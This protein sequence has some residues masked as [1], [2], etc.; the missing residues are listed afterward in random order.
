M[1][2]IKKIAITGASGVGKTTLAKFIAEQ[3]DMPFISAS[4]REVWPKFGFKNHQEAL[5]S[6][7]KDPMLGLQY[8]ENILLNRHLALTRSGSFVTD[9]SPIDNYAYF[10]LQQGYHSEEHNA[11]M[12]SLCL[13]DYQ[14]IDIVIFIRVGDQRE[15]EDNGRRI[16]NPSYQ[17]MVDE[18]IGMVLQKEFGNLTYKKSVLYIDTWDFEERKKLVSQ[19][20]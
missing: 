4:A 6:C 11:Y 12:K 14:N 5:S 13:M 18:V 19:L 8:Q 3:Y 9:R 16:C 2:E 10:L 17:R 7:L 20:F 1:G 15:I